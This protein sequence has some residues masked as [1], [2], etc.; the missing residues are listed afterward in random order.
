M[1]LHWKT[2]AGAIPDECGEVKTQGFGLSVLLRARSRRQRDQVQHRDQNE[3]VDGFI[4]QISAPG[5]GL[6]NRTTTVGLSFLLDAIVFPGVAAGI[7]APVEFR[8]GGRIFYGFAVQTLE[9]NFG[10]MTLRAARCVIALT[11]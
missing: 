1:G 4:S 2:H 7:T 10:G 3:R 11:L 5:P 9:D 6:R 8:F